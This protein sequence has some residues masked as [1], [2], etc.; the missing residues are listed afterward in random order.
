MIKKWVRHRMTD[1]I[2]QTETGRGAT[3]LCPA[4]LPWL[5]I[6]ACSFRASSPIAEI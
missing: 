4:I 1:S 2:M 5:R 6:A 3:P